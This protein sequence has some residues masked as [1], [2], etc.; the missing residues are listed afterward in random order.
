MELILVENILNLGK[1]GDK[2][3]VK[4]GYGRNYLLSNGKALRLNKE[5]LEFVNKKKD[6]LNKKNNELKKEF[7]LMAEKINNKTLN[8]FKES[9]DNGELYGAIKPKEI[10]NAFLNEL[11]IDI[12]PSYIVLKKD[13]NNI[14][15]YNVDINLYSEVSA[16]VKIIVKKTENK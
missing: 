6:E 8:F 14:G 12:K 1:I 2:V 16:K 5:N 9:K 7:K 13:I 3:K 15:D 11:K 10:A 4:N